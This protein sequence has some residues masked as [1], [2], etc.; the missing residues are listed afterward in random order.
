MLSAFSFC[1]LRSFCAAR[2]FSSR[3]RLPDDI[4]CRCIHEAPERKKAP[5]SASREESRLPAGH[6]SVRRSEH[7]GRP[8]RVRPRVTYSTVGR[9]RDDHEEQKWRYDSL[10][11]VCRNPVA[12][13]RKRRAKGLSETQRYDDEWRCALFSSKFNTFGGLTKF[14]RKFP[15]VHRRHHR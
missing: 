5:S 1:L 9:P 10:S 11:V 7:A 14:P 13:I 12:Y 2:R 4:L 15:D 6:C 3:R 8:V